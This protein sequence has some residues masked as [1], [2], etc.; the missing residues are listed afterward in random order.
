MVGDEAVDR[1]HREQ[2]ALVDEVLEQL[3][4]V[5]GLVVAAELRGLSIRVPAGRGWPSMKNRTNCA[6]T[7]ANSAAPTTVRTSDTMIAA[8]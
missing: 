2:L 4:V 6:M 3:G 7:R 5:D 8:S 1:G